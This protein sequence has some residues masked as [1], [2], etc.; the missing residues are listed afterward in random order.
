MILVFPEISKDLSTLHLEWD[1]TI[2]L[3]IDCVPEEEQRHLIQKL[4]NAFPNIN[5]QW[6][7][8]G[9]AEKK[10]GDIRKEVLLKWYK[11][12]GENEDLVKELM[13]IAYNIEV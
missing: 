5:N 1:D 13:N 12:S 8:F 11:P 7:Y 3:V 6:I 2:R 4:V 9:D 10:I